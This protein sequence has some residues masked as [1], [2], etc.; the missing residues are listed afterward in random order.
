MSLNGP[1]LTGLRRVLAEDRN[2]A[3]IQAEAARGFAARSE[4][5][6]ISAP[7]GMRATLLAEMADGLAAY[8][9][10]ETGPA[11]T[12][13]AGAGRPAPVVLAVTA[14]GRE[15][16]DLTEALRAFL[17]ADAVAEFPS[18]ETLPH[19]RL[20]PRSDTVGRRLSVLRR[21]AHPESSDRRCAARCGGP[22]PR[23]RAADRRRPGRTGA[24][25]PEARPGGS[26]QQRRQEPRRRR[27]RPGGHGDP[28][29]RV[30]RP[31]RHAG[32]LPAHRGPSHPGRVLWRRGGPD[33]LVRRRR[34]ALAVR[35]R[36]APSHR[37]PRPA[38][39]R[40]PDHAL[41]D[42][43]RGDAEVPAPGRRGHAGEDR[44]RHRRR[45]HGIAGPGAGGRHGAVPGP[46]PGR[47]HLGGDRAGEGPHT[48]PRP[49]RHQRGI[50]RGRLVHGV[51]RRH[52]TSGPQ[53]RGV[54]GAAL[55]Q[56]PVADRHP[57]GGPGARVFPGGP[58]PR[59]PPTKSC[60]P[61]STC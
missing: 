60:C 42:V 10:N 24:R 1:S 14:T 5:Y 59:W 56:F 4:D 46:A 22:R 61:T 32:R 43:P 44:R 55:G 47:F 37:T 15:A 27:L 38:V 12:G 9:A 25:D 16:E 48:G 23:R 17:P 6:Q 20:S 54:C 30:R 53:L 36:P 51:R 33:A 8:A 49:R 34:P 39:P 40:N 26:V 28:P 29:R 50:P 18:W 7:A 3:R 58:S 11:E 2:Y 57:H 13:S 31:R 19:E 45:G 52:G 21:L 41:R 35:A